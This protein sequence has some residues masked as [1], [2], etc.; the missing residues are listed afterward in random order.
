[1]T[2]YCA[3]ASENS[4]S[5]VSLL[6]PAW[7]LARVAAAD[8]SHPM[9]VTTPRSPPAPLGSGLVFQSLMETR[10]LHSP[11]YGPVTDNL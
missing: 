3:I 4:A 7:V 11:A 10:E 5:P 2:Q 9:L 8:T 1:M 6:R